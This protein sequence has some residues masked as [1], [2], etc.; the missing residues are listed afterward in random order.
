MSYSSVCQCPISMPPCP[1]LVFASDLL[2]CL[3][4]FYSS[5]YQCAIAVS[6]SL[7]YI[8]A[9]QSKF[10]VSPSVLLKCFP[11]S[12]YSVSLNPTAVFASALFQCVSMSFR[13][14]CQGTIT[15]LF[16][17]LRQ[18]F[19]CLFAVQLYFLKQWLPVSYSIVSQCPIAVSLY[20]LQQCFP[21]PYCSE[22]LCPTTVFSGVLL[23][24]LPMKYSSVSQCPIRESHMSNNTVY[25]CLITVSL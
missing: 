20:F 13:S 10:A 4:I 1:T 18:W 21:V 22:S 16:L 14:V 15:K 3:Y 12:K 25:Q 7:S 11:V 24:C 23:E 2:Q 8:N 17:F 19:D 5:G 6:L 9:C